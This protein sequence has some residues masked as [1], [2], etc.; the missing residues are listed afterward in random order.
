VAEALGMAPDD[1]TEV[2]LD[3]FTAW[4]SGQRRYPTL[5]QQNQ[6]WYRTILARAGKTNPTRDELKS[7]FAMPHGTA[8]YLAGVFYDPTVDTSDQ[9]LQ[10]SIADRIVEGIQEA[11]K[12]GVLGAETVTVWLTPKAGRALEALVIAALAD[13]PMTPPTIT[14][15]MGATR[16]T[17]S[18][19][20]GLHALCLA[21]GPEATTRIRAAA[22]LPERA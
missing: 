2:A 10:E 11:Q 16:V 4:L 5:S 18:A 21:L 6:D 17:F 8:Q 13:D 14:K 19:N 20:D 9:A 22:G 12:D 7:W 3:L 15:Q 1:L